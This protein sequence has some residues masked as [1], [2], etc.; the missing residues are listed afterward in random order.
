LWGGG[1]LWLFRRPALRVLG[2][3]YVILLAAMFA[4][5]AKDYYLAAV[6]PMLFAAGAV[7]LEAWARERVWPRVTVPAL[8]AATIPPLMILLLPILSPER[9]L[10][11]QVRL[12][13]TPQHLE[14]RHECPLDQRLGDQFGWEELARETAAVYHALP[15]E[16]RAVTGI[17]AGNYGEAGAI[18]Q[19]G[20]ALGLPPA[21]CSHQAHSYWGPPAVEPKILIC[22][23]CDEGLSRV[24]A[25]VTVA[26]THHHPF[27]MGEENRAIY[28]CRGGRTTLKAL[29]PEITHWN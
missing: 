13:I 15:P 12:G 4:L 9:L 28:V 27:G 24:F 19:F 16:E 17:Y 29:W 8:V 2:W 18:N 25:S 20:P 10:A 1:L 23:G 21:I 26:A 5:H 6:Y 11:L 7:G 22:L 3:F 14:T